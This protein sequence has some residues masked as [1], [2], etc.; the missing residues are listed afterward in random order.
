[1]TARNT[2][3]DGDSDGTLNASE[4]SCGGRTDPDETLAHFTLSVCVACQSIAKVTASAGSTRSTTTPSS[5]PKSR[6]TC[7]SDVTAT[8][9]AAPR[10][11]TLASVRTWSSSTFGGRSMVIS[12]ASSN[13]NVVADGNHVRSRRSRAVVRR[14]KLICS[15]ATSTLLT[16]RSSCAVPKRR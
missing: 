15:G 6:R 5:S 9:C 3:S 2:P 11:Q 16:V 12:D 4:C 1:M 8:L 10:N 7:L 14:S 13:E